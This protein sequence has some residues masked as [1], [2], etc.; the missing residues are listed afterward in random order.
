M[1]QTVTPAVPKAILLASEVADEVDELHL[2]LWLDALVV[3]VCVEHDDRERQ[4]EH[5]VRLVEPCGLI[6]IAP[7]IPTSE[8]LR[9]E[10]AECNGSN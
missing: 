7:A 5:R 3:E 9:A 2:A 8:S 4:K 10:I 1:F 6:C